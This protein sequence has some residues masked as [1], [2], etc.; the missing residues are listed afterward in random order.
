MILTF[1]V[2]CYGLLTSGIV[3][4]W[5]MFDKK[6]HIVKKNAEQFSKFILLKRNHKFFES[7]VITDEIWTYALCCNWD[8]MT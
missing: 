4:S 8:V 7:Y 6:L 2:N 1:I 5:I 3:S